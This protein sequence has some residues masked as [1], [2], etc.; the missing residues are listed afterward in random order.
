MFQRIWISIKADMAS[1]SSS[2]PQWKYRAMS[3]NWRLL[4]FLYNSSFT[5]IP[6]DIWHRNDEAVDET[7]NA[8]YVPLAKRKVK[9]SIIKER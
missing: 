6:R 1:W 8:P 7:K 2:D 9:L 3:L 5:I 4:F